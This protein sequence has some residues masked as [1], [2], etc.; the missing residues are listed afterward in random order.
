MR[1]YV[2]SGEEPGGVVPEALT[3]ARPWACEFSL[4]RVEFAD[5]RHRVVESPSPNLTSL[6]SGYVLILTGGPGEQAQAGSIAS[7]VTVETASTV[8]PFEGALLRWAGVELTRPAA[9]PELEAL[10]AMDAEIDDAYRRA[11]AA[12]AAEAD[13]WMFGDP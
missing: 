5:P 6:Q 1:D 8:C 12:L 13:D 10:A 11:E 9:D 2:L 7:C 3:V 4:D